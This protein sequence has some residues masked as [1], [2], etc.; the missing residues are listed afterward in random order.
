MGISP[1]EALT[2]LEAFY[3]STGLGAFSYN[4][5]LELTACVPEDMATYEAVFLSVKRV[6]DSMRNIF[7]ES[8]GNADSRRQYH[9]LVTKLNFFINIVPVYRGGEI[10]GALV[11]EPVLVKKMTREEM[12]KV[13]DEADSL[14]A[15]RR[16]MEKSLLETPIVPY[17]KIMPLGR[18]LYG[19]AQSFFKPDEPLQ[20]MHRGT[21]GSEPGTRGRRQAQPAVLPK[22]PR[23]SSLSTF[24]TIR[25]TIQ[26]G[27]TAAL[28][29]VMNSISAGDIPMDQLKRSDFVRSV[30]DSLI[31][32]CSL[33]CYAA[34]DGGASYEHAMDLL[35]DFVRRAEMLSNIYDIY[36][37]MKNAMLS[38]SRA[39]TMG[40]PVYTKPV[41]Q[42]MEYIE[43]HYA[44]KITLGQLSAHTG[45]STFYLSTLIRKETGRTLPDNINKVRV[46]KSMPL[47]RDKNRSIRDVAR[48]VGFSH[49]NQY[50]A[51]FKKFAE[52]TP[53]RFRRTPAIADPAA[54]RRFQ[55]LS[56]L[57]YNQLEYL[58]KMLPGLIDTARIVDPERHRCWLIGQPTPPA[59]AE[60]CY[61]FWGRNEC[62]ENC[63]S[64]RAFLT[65]DTI[66]KVERGAKSDFLVLAV[67]R[68]VGE[69]IYVVELLKK[70]PGRIILHGNPDETGRM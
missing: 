18:V 52:T 48:E 59:Q 23:H 43:A 68:H 32:A 57:A 67:P 5:Q 51:A 38:F 13:M 55:D 27:D 40:G 2:V 16:A 47:L 42:A 69:R 49:P 63:I 54:V 17:E 10:V 20:V 65:D 44:E 7:A 24:V 50:S 60:A 25:S 3:K 11:S 28:L 26:N 1:S 53:G 4:R 56:Q 41:G 31:K 6:T 19:L 35:D 14:P 34:I 70:L 62:C 45:L 12:W 66:F 29:D 8:D 21:P 58:L 37:L 9:T 61:R 64:K 33:G 46:E 30:K 36:E 39:V 22:A 15:N